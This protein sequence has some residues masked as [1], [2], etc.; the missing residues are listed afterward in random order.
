[1][2]KLLEEKN[3]GSENWFACSCFQKNNLIL[4]YF[5]VP[6]AIKM[7]KPNKYV[8]HD[9]EYRFVFV[10]AIK[11]QRL[12]LDIVHLLRMKSEHTDVLTPPIPFHG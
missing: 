4:L 8:Y 2:G 3:I 7:I 10:R 9:C 6:K 1:M 12:S 5:Q 11:R